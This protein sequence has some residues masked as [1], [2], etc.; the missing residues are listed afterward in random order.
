MASIFA[1]RTRSP[2]RDRQT[3]EARFGQLSRAL[4]ELA[5]GIEAERTGI[6]NRYEAVSA[7]AAFLVEAMENSAVSVLRAREMDQMTESLKACL[8]RIEALGR[9]KD[10]V[11]GLRHSLDIFADEGRETDEE[12]SARLAQ[13]EALRQF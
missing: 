11:A 3:D 4:D 10:F 6:R 5:A 12:S 13:G 1:F 2:D 7:N 8:R 9:Q